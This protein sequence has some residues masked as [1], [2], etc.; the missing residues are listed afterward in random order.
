MAYRRGS[1]RRFRPR[2]LLRRRKRFYRRRRVRAGRGSYRA[3]LTK[4]TSYNVLTDK[5]ATFSMSVLPVDFEEWKN[6][7]RNF[8]AYRMT[9]MKVTVIPTVNMG[10][11]SVD[12]SGNMTASG[13]QT[14]Y[15]IAPWHR[16]APT[17]P[18][19]FEEVCSIDRA[20]IYRM[21]QKGSMTFNVNTLD[22]GQTDDSATSG[23]PISIQWKHRVEM[24]AS[25]GS[26]RHYAGLVSFMPNPLAV[27]DKTKGVRVIV[28]QDVWC[29]FYNQNT[30]GV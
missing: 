29:T 7:S 18:I 8:E 28:K 15:A 20:K 12:S 3:K 23:K 16:H 2:R 27:T 25:A 11:Q 10:Q 17:E 22:M 13:A 4:I 9:K 6:L 19:S 5:V 24:D 30:L 1:K 14:L 21:F 26:V